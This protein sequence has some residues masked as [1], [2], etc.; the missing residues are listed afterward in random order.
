MSVLELIQSTLAPLDIPVTTLT[1][2]ARA[3]V[4]A[5]V[6]EFDDSPSQRADN[7]ETMTDSFVQIDFIAR[8][9]I[10]SL[11]TQAIQLLARAG[12]IRRGKRTEHNEKSGTYRHM[13][14]WILRTRY[15]YEETDE[16]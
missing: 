10:E 16:E 11:V 8:T 13:T 2:D 6:F 7:A 5:V 9:N 14:R 1:G 3:P 12:F 15:L 4:Y